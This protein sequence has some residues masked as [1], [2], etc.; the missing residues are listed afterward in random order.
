MRKKRN[1]FALFELILVLGLISVLLTIAIPRYQHAIN[2]M[3]TRIVTNKIL[4]ALRFAQSH[5]AAANQ[6]IVYCGSKDPAHC[7][8]NWSLG[9]LIL[10][11]ANGEIL[12]R[13]AAI[14]EGGRLWWKSSLGYDDAL[15]LAPSG[16]TNGQR[17]SFYYCPRN[18]PEQYGTIITIIDSGRARIVTDPQQLI[19][20]CSSLETR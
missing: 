19:A 10:N 15:K 5:A 1:G 7:D 8:G 3:H 18:H 6:V 17:G 9:Q 13:Y 4:D 11:D 20:A 14:P 12:H 2:Q 16:F